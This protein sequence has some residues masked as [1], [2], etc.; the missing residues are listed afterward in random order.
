M[1]RRGTKRGRS[2]A[3]EALAAALASGKAATEAAHLAGVSL[4]T[5]W[6]RLALPEFRAR[7]EKLRGEMISAAAGKLSAAMSEAAD[8]LKGLL[9]STDEHVRHK[10]GVKVIELALRVVELNELERRVSELEHRDQER[11]RSGLTPSRNGRA[12]R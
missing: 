6:R 5:V 4:R 2:G 3:D 8:V 7:V 9:A 12:F 10:A 1:A 11:E